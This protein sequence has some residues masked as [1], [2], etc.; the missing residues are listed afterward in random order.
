MLDFGRI[1]VANTTLYNVMF[2]ISTSIYLWILVVW[3][4]DRRQNVT[5]DRRQN[6]TSNRHQKHTSVQ[7]QIWT[8]LR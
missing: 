3:T 6:V 5:S 8:L 2:L 4:L 7:R 1:L